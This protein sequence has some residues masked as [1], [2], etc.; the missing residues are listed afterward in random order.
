[1]TDDKIRDALT[2]TLVQIVPEADFNT[3]KPDRP[4]RDQLDIDSFDFLR[5]MIALHEHIGVEIPEADYPKL[6]TLNGALEYLARLRQSST[7]P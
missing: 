6:S 7:Q 5:W 1:M 2:E 4:L 3:L